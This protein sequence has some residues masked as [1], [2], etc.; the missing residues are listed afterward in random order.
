MTTARS[1]IEWYLARDG[2]QYGP[3]SDAEMRKFVELGHLKPTDLLWRQ[4]FADWRPATSVFPEPAAPAPRPSPPPEPMHRVPDSDFGAHHRT[5]SGYRPAARDHAETARART[6]SSRTLPAEPEPPLSDPLADDEFEP[7]SRRPRWRRRLAVVLGLIAV[8]GGGGWYAASHLDDLP[9]PSMLLWTVSDGAELAPPPLEALRAPP[10]QGVAETEQAT[11]RAW[12]QSALWQVLKENFPEWYQERLKE[13]VQ[14]KSEGKPEAE[15]AR[16]L[17][18]GI[19]TLRRRYAKEALAASPAALRALASTFVANLKHLTEHNVEACFG[20]ISQ[21]E[22]NP[23]VLQLMNDP[24]HLQHL[25]LQMTSVFEAVSDG[26]RSPQTHLPPRRSDY[27]ALTQALKK[28]GWSDA[29]LQLFS[30][31]KQLARAQPQ[32]VCKMVQDWFGA[33]LGMKDRGVQVRLLVESLRPV[34]AG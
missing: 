20:F 26:R 1:D 28:R 12:Q 23:Q 27:D 29:D 7:H 33:Q 6:G 11:D 16:T 5:G 9:L 8:L 22:T 4:G 13:A 10:F 31:P 14:L 24:D 32:V 25:Q 18:S 15:I 21:G 30:D 19:V 2:Q 3:L 34:V 17:A